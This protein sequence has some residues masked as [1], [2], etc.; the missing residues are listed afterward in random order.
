[1]TNQSASKLYIREFLVAMVAYV[2]V[3]PISITLIIASPPTA[4]WRIPLA[5]ARW[6]PSFLR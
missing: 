3:L 6:F 4:W 2:I 1:M 5:L